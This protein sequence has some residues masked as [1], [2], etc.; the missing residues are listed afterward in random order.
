MLDFEA[1]KRRNRAVRNVHRDAIMCINRL[2]KNSEPDKWTEEFIDSALTILR[3]AKIPLSPAIGQG[4]LESGWGKS[5]VLF[6]IKARQTDFKA[7]KAS[8]HITKE[9]MNG[10]WIQVKAFFFLDISMRGEFDHYLDL[11]RRVHPHFAEHYPAEEQEY[12][13]YILRPEKA[14]A[15]DPEYKSKVLNVIKMAGLKIFDR[16]ETYYQED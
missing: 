12:L 1:L 16:F 9:F 15:T 3:P 10:R 7:G 6:G 14:Y 2:C 13:D 8:E 5:N 11:A 4:L